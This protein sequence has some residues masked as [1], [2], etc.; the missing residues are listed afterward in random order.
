[1]YENESNETA[2][3][4]TFSDVTHFAAIEFRISTKTCMM[5]IKDIG[6]V[7]EAGLSLAQIVRW[8]W[9]QKGEQ[10]IKETKILHM[11]ETVEFSIKSLCSIVI[12]ILKK[13]EKNDK[14]T[15][16]DDLTVNIG[17]KQITVPSQWLMSVS[18]VINRMLSVE[19][20]E[21]QQRSI[22][23]DELGVDMEQFMEFLDNI[24]VGTSNKKILP[25]PKNVLLLLQLADFFQV[26]S[27]KSRCESHLINCVEI[28]LIDR[29]LLIDQYHLDHLK[30]YFLNLRVDNLRAFYKAN[31][32]Q[33]LPVLNKN[34]LDELTNRI[35]G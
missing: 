31:R 1:M 3:T 7:S 16:E 2:R 29:F 11:G 10:E 35:C 12:R 15:S 28:P 17:D 5:Q 20:L 25:N 34:F 13:R 19:M 14:N 27:L 4:I 8:E 33:M 22:S 23:F 9:D 32:A 18:P 26:D 6:N 24:S 30:N 21:K